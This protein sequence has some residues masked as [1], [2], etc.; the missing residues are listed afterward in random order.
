MTRHQNS[1]IELESYRPQQT[2]LASQSQAELWYQ[3]VNAATNPQELLLLRASLIDALPPRA[4]YELHPD[5]FASVA[6]IYRMKHTLF[7]RLQ[8][9]PLI[10]R[11]RSEAA[12]A[13]DRDT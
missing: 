9:T 10:E 12:F 8:H 5:Q 3:I 11:L 1:A 4:I 7:K 2:L 13:P 6:A